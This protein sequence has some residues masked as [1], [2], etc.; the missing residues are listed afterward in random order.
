MLF[1]DAE[2]KLPVEDVRMRLRRKKNG[3][4]LLSAD[5][6]SLFVDISVGGLGMS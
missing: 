5:R 2:T 6:P 4:W 3:W 1:A